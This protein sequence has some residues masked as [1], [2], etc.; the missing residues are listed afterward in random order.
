MQNFNKILRKK[1]KTYLCIDRSRLFSLFL[2]LFF[3]FSRALI[4]W[5]GLCWTRNKIMPDVL[6]ELIVALP[7]VNSLDVKKWLVRAK[8]YYKRIFRMP[9]IFSKRW[10]SRLS[11]LILRFLEY[12]LPPWVFRFDSIFSRILRVVCKAFKTMVEMEHNMVF[13]FRST[14]VTSVWFFY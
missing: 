5:T 13:F 1:A 6:F 2:C 9:E 3:H 12:Y 10:N 14:N 7:N 8:S 4:D 11:T